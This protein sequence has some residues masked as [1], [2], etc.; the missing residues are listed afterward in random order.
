MLTL[1]VLPHQALLPA[2]MG[3]LCCSR[4]AL[5][6]C[7][8][9]LRLARAREGYS[10]RYNPIQPPRSQR[11]ASPWRLPTPSGCRP[12]L[13]VPASFQRCRVSYQGHLYNLLVGVIPPS[14]RPPRTCIVQTKGVLVG[15]FLFTVHHGFDTL[16]TVLLPAPPAGLWEEV[17]VPTAHVH[18][19]LLRRR[20]GGQLAGFSGCI[21]YL[22]APFIMYIAPRE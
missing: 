8:V 15:S 20:C 3:H 9:S 7:F 12:R 4:D 14:V 22:V 19:L 21:L 17:R 16:D 5:R 18:E 10:A 1:L 13:A 11:S 2:H 6:L